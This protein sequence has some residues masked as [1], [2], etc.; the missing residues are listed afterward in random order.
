M[1]ANGMG[2]A[3]FLGM[4][5]RN[6]ATI[7]CHLYCGFRHNTSFAVYQD[8]QEADQAANLLLTKGVVMICGSLAMQ[9]DRPCWKPSGRPNSAN[10]SASI[11]RATRY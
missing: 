10:C 3:L 1:V 8:R 5:N 6:R 2:I 9:K 7:P 4:N 11:N